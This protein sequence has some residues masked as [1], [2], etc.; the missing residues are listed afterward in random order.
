M[1]YFMISMLAL[2]YLDIFY[3][4]L[5]LDFIPR[6]PVLLNVI[7]A[8]TENGAQFLLTALLMLVIIFVYTNIGFFYL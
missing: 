8:V 2:F 5:L 1:L 6:S 4:F 3:A 7:R